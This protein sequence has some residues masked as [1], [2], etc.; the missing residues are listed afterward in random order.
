MKEEQISLQDLW[1][2]KKLSVCAQRE[3]DLL[4]THFL[5]L[6]KHTS[7]LKEAQ[8]HQWDGRNSKFQLSTLHQNIYFSAVFPSV[9]MPTHNE[10][11]SSSLLR[12]KPAIRARPRAVTWPLSSQLENFFS[13]QILLN[14]ECCCRSFSCNRKAGFLQTVSDEAAVRMDWLSVCSHP[15]ASAIPRFSTLISHSLIIELRI[16]CRT[17]DRGRLRWSVV[18]KN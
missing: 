8:T 9:K 14:L 15:C 3:A 18:L 7:L 4:Y 1:G 13:Y 5:H 11:D 12:P 16:T 17:S 6:C 2:N 10:C